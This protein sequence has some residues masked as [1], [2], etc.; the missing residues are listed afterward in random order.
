[1]ADEKSQMAQITQAQTKAN[2]RNVNNRVPQRP[3]AL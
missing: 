3:A 1:M 2:A